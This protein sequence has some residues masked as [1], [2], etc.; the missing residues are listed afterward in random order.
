M[1]RDH[2]SP[3]FELGLGFVDRTID[4]HQRGGRIAAEPD[5]MPR[6]QRVTISDE[7]FELSSSIA[8]RLDFTRLVLPPKAQLGRPRLTR[9]TPDTGMRWD[10]R[11][12]HREAL[13][14]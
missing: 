14:H 3:R 10:A 9:A 12:A 5:A 6:Q 13:A 2:R 7:P 8:C 11:H 1:I 4:L